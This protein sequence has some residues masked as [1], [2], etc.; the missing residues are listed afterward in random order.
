MRTRN[1]DALTGPRLRDQIIDAGECVFEH[2]WDS[3]G[4]GAGAGVERVYRWKGK[5]AFSSADNGRAGPF[6]T[7]DDALEAQD[8][9]RVT[10]ASTSIYCSLLKGDELAGQ[11]TC[12]E[13]GCLVTVNG[14]PWEYDQQAGRFEPRPDEEGEQEE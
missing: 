12:E 4:P 10:D 5:F 7:L 13:D 6:N 14:E 2:E 11:M 3:G 1:G 8:L 9:L